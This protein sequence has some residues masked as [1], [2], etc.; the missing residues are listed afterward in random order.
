[1]ERASGVVCAARIA[2]KAERGRSEWAPP[3]TAG[4][5]MPCGRHGKGRGGHAIGS[6]R[7]A[8]RAQALE[9]ARLAFGY[10]PKLRCGF[11]FLFLNFYFPKIQNNTKTSF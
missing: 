9:Q 7:G 3:L 2:V 8:A 1:M 6:R 4:D 5:W 10:G 11:S